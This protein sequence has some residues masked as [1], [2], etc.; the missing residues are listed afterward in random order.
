MTHSS[1]A[2]FAMSN[3]IDIPVIR[4]LIWKI[5]RRLYFI[6]R[7]DVSNNPDN[8]G[9]YWLLEKFLK[10]IPSTHSPILMD[11]GANKGNWTAKANETLLHQ[12]KTGIIYAFEP[13]KATYEFLAKRFNAKKNI[14]LNKLAL[15][16]S[17]GVTDFFVIEA[18]AGTNSLHENKDSIVEKV[19]T[20][21]F[22]DYVEKND[23]NAIAFVKIDTEGHDLSV[24]HGA[25]NSLMKGRIEI[26]QFEYNHR[27]ILNHAFLK[28]V[29]DLIEG[30]PYSLGKIYGNGIEIYQKWH[31]ELEKFIEAN[32]I[33]IRHGS[34]MEKYGKQLFF[35]QSNVAV[36]KP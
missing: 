19:Q 25:K 10:E 20:T 13:A 9:E 36:V 16:N 15:S 23:L 14:T 17:I 24:L 4:S 34:Y 2:L 28:D 21:T 22:D 30:T 31:P 5:S 32:Y 27:W 11:I 29:F 18:L 26:C 8:N 12:A 6:A 7:R 3:L 1:I 33:L 35:T